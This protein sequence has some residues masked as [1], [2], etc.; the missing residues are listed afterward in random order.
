VP[1][2]APV[3]VGGQELPQLPEPQALPLGLH[4]MSE[5]QPEP[6]RERQPESQSWLAQVLEEPLPARNLHYSEQV[7]PLEPEQVLNSCIRSKS[8][9]LKERS[10]SLKPG[11][12]LAWGVSVSMLRL[13][14]NLLG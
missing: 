14:E 2:P 5:P 13:K 4:S 8:E 11:I 7:Q 6:R 3:V 12:Y 9:M 1:L 10:L